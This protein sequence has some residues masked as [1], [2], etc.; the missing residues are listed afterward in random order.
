MINYIKEISTKIKRM[1]GKLNKSPTTKVFATSKDDEMNDVQVECIGKLPVEKAC[2]QENI[3]RFSQTNNTPPMQDCVVQHIGYS[4]TGDITDSILN[5]TFMDRPEWDYYLN[6]LCHQ[7]YIPLKNTTIPQHHKE[8]SLEEHI[9]SWKKQNEIISSDTSS[10]SF[11]HHKA[12]IQDLELAN[13][14]RIFRD[15]PFRTGFIPDKWLN[16]TDLAILKKAGVYEVEKMRTIMLM[17]AEFNINNKK[18]GRD[19][20]Y[21]AELN[22]TLPR[23][24]Y[25]C[26]KH[27][28]SISFLDMLDIS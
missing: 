25:G 8:I 13:V 6:L 19:M 28:K 20:M 16:I 21:T 24:Q 11:S 10:L 12:F 1:R 18:L 27:H 4:A 23:E 26:R 3:L 7:M 9:S 14:D 17:S 2:R 5:G 15:I 22:N